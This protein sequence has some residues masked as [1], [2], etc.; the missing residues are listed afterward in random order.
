M[1]VIAGRRRA[2]VR[3]GNR[4]A[5]IQFLDFAFCAIAKH[6]RELKNVAGDKVFGM[7]IATDLRYSKR[8]DEV[9]DFVSRNVNV[10]P[11]DTAPMIAAQVISEYKINQG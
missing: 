6:A 9:G 3:V 11:T 4:R 8:G 1:V 10:R 2:G 7:E 5:I